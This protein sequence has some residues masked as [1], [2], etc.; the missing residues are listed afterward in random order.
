MRI[1]ATIRITAS[2]CLRIL[3][4]RSNAP[5]CYKVGWQGL[6]AQSTVE[7]ELVAAPLAM[8]ES[9]FCSNTDEESGIRHVVRPLY[10]DSTLTLHV[11]GSRTY[12]SQVKHAALPY[13]I[14]QE[15]V[16]KERITVQYVRTEDQLADI[17]T[18]V[19]TSA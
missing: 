5:V 14:F 7:A 4:S 12:S 3:S 9:V 16:K 10:N 15:L 11:A 6:T 8:K 17:G 1:G 13:F 19:S 18:A 2:P